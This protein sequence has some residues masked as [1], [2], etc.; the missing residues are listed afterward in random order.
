MAT[1][2]D[3]NAMQVASAFSADGSA[4]GY[5]QTGPVIEQIPAVELKEMR[6]LGPHP[7]MAFTV[8]AAGM[9]HVNFYVFY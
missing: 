4:A 7:C 1:W 9:K 8:E 6:L 5:V 3:V 2:T